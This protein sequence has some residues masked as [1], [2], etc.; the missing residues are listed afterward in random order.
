MRRRATNAR[1]RRA[2]SVG[3]L[4]NAAGRQPYLK[5][6]G[7]QNARRGWT[8]SLVS[9]QL[10]KKWL[11]SLTIEWVVGLGQ[12]WGMKRLMRGLLGA[13]IGAAL[14]AGAESVVTSPAEVLSKPR[15][16]AGRAVAAAVIGGA[17]AFLGRKRTK[18]RLD[19]SGEE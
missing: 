5:N 2:E 7:G 6:R 1:G 12:D 17:M 15:E 13:V 8:R 4:G 14:E 11:Q 19:R 9:R 16:V 10:E 18:V 3:K